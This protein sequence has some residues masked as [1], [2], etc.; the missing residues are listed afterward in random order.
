LEYL[1]AKAPLEVKEF[2]VS[3]SAPAQMEIS[4]AATTRSISSGI[5]D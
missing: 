2:V 4:A 1:A 3:S 5:Q